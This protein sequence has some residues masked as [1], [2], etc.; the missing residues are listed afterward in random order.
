MHKTRPLFKYCIKAMPLLREVGVE[1]GA[2]RERE[3]GTQ[4][5]NEEISLTSS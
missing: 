1:G 3:G 5:R 2:Q 4:A